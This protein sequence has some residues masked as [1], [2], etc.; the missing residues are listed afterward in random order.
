MSPVVTFE[1]KYFKQLNNLQEHVGR[2]P[3]NNLSG[4]NL[5]NSELGSLIS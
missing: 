1:F 4:H 5:R 2:Q 3:E